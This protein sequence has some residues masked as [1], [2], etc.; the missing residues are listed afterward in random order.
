MLKTIR[1]TTLATLAALALP[2]AVLPACEEKSA[3]EKLGDSI[4]ETLEDAGDAMEE[5]ADDAADAVE[6]ATEG[7]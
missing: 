7:E 2:L 3:S 4:G 6:D 5:A 1:I